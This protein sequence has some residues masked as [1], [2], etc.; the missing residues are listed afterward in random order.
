MFLCIVH[1]THPGGRKLVTTSALA[2]C[3]EGQGHVRA[4]RAAAPAVGGVAESAT[5]QGQPW[6]EWLMDDADPE[7]GGEEHDIEGEAAFSLPEGDVP[8]PFQPGAQLLVRP[9]PTAQ[10]A[11]RPGFA[12]AQRVSEASMTDEQ[13]QAC[14]RR[15]NSC[16][17]EMR[18]ALCMVAQFQS[19]E[20]RWEGSQAQFMEAVNAALLPAWRC[21]NTWHHRAAW[22]EAL[23]P[24]LGSADV[25]EAL[26]VVSQGV[27]IKLVQDPCS[28]RQQGR[29]DFS[30]KEKAVMGMLG[31]DSPQVRSLL[32][33]SQLPRIW[34]GNMKSAENQENR[35]FITEQV[36][37]ALNNGTA[38]PWQ[39]AWG[40]PYLLLPLGC[41]TNARSDKKRMTVA[42]LPLNWWEEYVSFNQERRQ[43]GVG[44]QTGWMGAER[45][46]PEVRM[47]RLEG[48]G[49]LLPASATF[50][51]GWGELFAERGLLVQVGC[52]GRLPHAGHPS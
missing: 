13:W 45:R 46:A 47:C 51:A 9:Q 1:A 35:Q 12:V 49:R 23:R 39:A 48:K 34:L 31:G 17:T 41:A 21:G 36:D 42:P 50:T 25:A 18:E 24:M 16:S 20:G 4:L 28:A 5:G 52:Q 30:K 44:A 29:P 14:E 19:P 27:R 38:V 43:V 10:P 15:A 3:R 37:A 40:E 7:E 6:G 22:A 32:R 2:W 11:Q 8:A 33:S 26:R